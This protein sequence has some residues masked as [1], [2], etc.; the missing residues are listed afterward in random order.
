MPFI[1]EEM[2]N[3][4][5]QAYITAYMLK[6][7]PWRPPDPPPLHLHQSPVAPQTPA[8]SAR[9]SSHP[10]GSPLHTDRGIVYMHVYTSISIATIAHY[11][12]AIIYIYIQVYIAY[13][14]LISPIY[15]T[16]LAFTKGVLEMSPAGR[17][18]RHIG[19]TARGATQHAGSALQDV[20]QEAVVLKALQIRGV[21][22]L[23]DHIYLYVQCT[24]THGC[25]LVYL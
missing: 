18:V 11:I 1:F 9:S 20:L 13:K 19:L 14:L 12:Y 23:S 7:R 3:S 22:N 5:Q 25:V 17:A 4:F 8:A 10:A 24:Y 2:S 6:K 21:A 15:S 16:S